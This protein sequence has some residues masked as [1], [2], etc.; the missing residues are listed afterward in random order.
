[1][2]YIPKVRQIKSDF[3]GVFYID[4]IPESS[5]QFFNPRL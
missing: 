1:M 3:W 2:N 5:Q 4:R